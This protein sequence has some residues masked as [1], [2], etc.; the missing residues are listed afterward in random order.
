MTNTKYEIDQELYYIESTIGKV[1]WLELAHG[2]VVN[3]HEDLKKLMP[4]D[5]VIKV[6]VCSIYVDEINGEV[7]YSVHEL[8][9]RPGKRFAIEEDK[10]YENKVDA[11]KEVLE[12]K[13]SYLKHIQDELIEISK[14]LIE[15][16]G[17][18]DVKVTVNLPWKFHGSSGFGGVALLRDGVFDQCPEPMDPKEVAYYRKLKEEQ[19]RKRESEQ[20]NK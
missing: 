14:T 9:K 5:R 16:E 1:G 12:R 2:I 19:D 13:S 15:L 10:L 17:G 11:L 3:T 6:K 4:V 7:R 18:T 20:Q 8:S